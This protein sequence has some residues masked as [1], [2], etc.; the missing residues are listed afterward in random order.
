MK[1]LASWNTTVRRITPLLIWIAVLIVTAIVIGKKA[2]G[3]HIDTADIILIVL[4]V[5]GPL[6]A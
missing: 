1:P 6:G 2:S 3:Q 5:A 4:V